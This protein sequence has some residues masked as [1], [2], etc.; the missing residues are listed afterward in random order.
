VWDRVSDPIRSSEARQRCGHSSTQQYGLPPTRNP[1]MVLTSACFFGRAKAED[2][3]LIKE[4]ALEVPYL[5]GTLQELAT[6]NL[7]FRTQ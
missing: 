1:E 6:L 2:R 3:K 4:L 5:E 7:A